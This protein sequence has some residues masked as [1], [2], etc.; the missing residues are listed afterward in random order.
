MCWIDA[1]GSLNEIESRAK[2][3]AAIDVSYSLDVKKWK[4]NITFS[5]QRSYLVSSLIIRTVFASSSP[6]H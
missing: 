3:K 5:S 6:T 2:V 4:Q 1:S